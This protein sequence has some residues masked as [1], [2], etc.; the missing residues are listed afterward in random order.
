MTARKV[1]PPS[2]VGVD[3]LAALPIPTPAELYAMRHKPELMPVPVMTAEQ[4]CN[5]VRHQFACFAVDACTLYG[6]VRRWRWYGRPDRLDA[7]YDIED[8]Y[9]FRL[10]FREAEVGI[11][12]TAQTSLAQEFA[13]RGWTLCFRPLVRGRSPSLAPDVQVVDVVWVEATQA[14]AG[15]D[16][17]A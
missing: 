9:S 16:G 10:V 17:N 4:L 5:V 3:P 1:A 14:E 15:K 11:T 6:W 12:E 7:G 13:K 8:V 2:W